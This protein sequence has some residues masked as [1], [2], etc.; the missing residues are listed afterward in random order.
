MTKR[1][2]VDLNRSAI[3]SLAERHGLSNVRLFGSV[4]RGEENTTSDIDFLVT[5]GDGSDPFELL[6]FKEALEE[7]L[8]CKVDVLTDH[9]WMRPRL[10]NRIAQDAVPV[11]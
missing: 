10:R 9:R 8:R 3:A 11:S 2:R 7:L 1:E 6:A 4:A 5:R